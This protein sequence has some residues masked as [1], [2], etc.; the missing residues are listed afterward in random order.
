M[1]KYIGVFATACLTRRQLQDLVARL[2]QEGE[3]RCEKAYAG[4][5]DGILVCLFQAPNRDALNDFLQQN[6]MVAENLWRID[7]ESQDGVLVSV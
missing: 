3:V 7:L 2:S 4:L 5:V 6:G 1:A